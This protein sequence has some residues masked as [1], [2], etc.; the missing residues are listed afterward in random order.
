VRPHRRP[1]RDRGAGRS[2]RR[3]R[4][5]SVTRTLLTLGG[6]RATLCGMIP[7]KVREQSRPGRARPPPGDPHAPVVSRT[8]ASRY[9]STAR[10]VLGDGIDTR[11]V[12]HPTA[13]GSIPTSASPA[14]RH[15][16]KL[17]PARA[18]GAPGVAL[19]A[20]YALRPCDRRPR[21]FLSRCGPF[22]IVTD[23]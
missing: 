21:G 8:L 16:F 11:G 5:V 19:G 10:N 9:G 17:A 3:R 2:F 6:L 14:G 15:R 4:T 18:N 13:V 12:R 22:P 7:R 20:N 23:R 1:A